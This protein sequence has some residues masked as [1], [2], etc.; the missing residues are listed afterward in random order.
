MSEQRAARVSR[1]QG[2]GN[3]EQGT[4]ARGFRQLKAWQ[5][6]D[7]LATAIF[8]LTEKELDTRHRWLGLQ[9]V[10]AAFSVTSNIAEGYGRSALAD[11]ARFLELA[12]ASL[13]EVENGLHFIRRNEIVPAETLKPIEQLRWATGNL[14]FGLA[15]ALRAKLNNKGEW[16]RGLIKDEEGEYRTDSERESMFHVPSSMFPDAEAHHG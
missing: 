10:R 6:A 11:Y 3:R 5:S 15:R 14:L 8:E 4:E 9:I 16:Q 2:T 1:E 12:G 7:H 13:N